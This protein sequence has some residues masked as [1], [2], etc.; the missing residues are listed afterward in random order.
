VDDFDPAYIE[1]HSPEAVVVLG[2]D[3]TVQSVASAIIRSNKA[4]KIGILPGGGGNDIFERW[5]NRELEFFDADG[6]GSHP[7]FKIEYPDGQIEFATNTIEWGIGAI[8]AE[9][10]E[11]NE[12]R[13]FLGIS[14]YFYLLLKALRLYNSWGSKIIID[15]EEFYY[16]DLS[17]V[18]VGFGASSMGGGF[19][20]FPEELEGENKRNAFVLIARGFGRKNGMSLILKL[21]RMKHFEDDRVIYRKC[22]TLELVPDEVEA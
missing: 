18:V 21:A 22:S 8:V 19:I 6:F 3:G 12:G 15:G 16:D 17:S 14:K 1:E 9:K 13:L 11:N 4:V 7:I 20:M 10:R 5:Y 2:G